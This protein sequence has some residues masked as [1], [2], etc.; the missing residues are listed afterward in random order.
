MNP[1]GEIFDEVFKACLKV[2]PNVFDYV[3]PMAERE[4]RPYPFIYVGES[5]T[6]DEPTKDKINGVTSQTVHVYELL[7]RRQSLYTLMAQIATQVRKIENTAHYR[8]RVRYSN[9]Q[10]LDDNTESVPLLH[11]ILEFEIHFS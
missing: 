6:V 7:E 1:Y 9:P 4:D 8:L 11:G 5:I 10:V 2:H 3:K